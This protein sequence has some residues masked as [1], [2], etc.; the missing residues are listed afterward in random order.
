MSFNF[1]L[2]SI[3]KIPKE[4]DEKQRLALEKYTALAISNIDWKLPVR[5]CF[6]AYWD[7]YF[8]KK[9]FLSMN[10]LQLGHVALSNACPTSLP[11]YHVLSNKLF[12]VLSVAK[13]RT[14]R[15]Q[16]TVLFEPIVEN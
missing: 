14:S 2:E 7:S 4:E 5:I 12:G 16:N 10:T 15:G 6:L 13:R 1:N 11:F 8:N 3:L 9:N